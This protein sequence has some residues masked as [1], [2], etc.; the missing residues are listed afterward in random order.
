[1]ST[2]SKNFIGMNRDGVKKYNPFV[3][4]MICDQLDEQS[5]SRID[6]LMQEIDS[7][8]DSIILEN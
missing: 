6:I 4:P 8:M 7:N 2:G 1:M 5:K 3:K